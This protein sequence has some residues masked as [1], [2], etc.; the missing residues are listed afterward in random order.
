ME[1]PND[2]VMVEVNTDKD[3]EAQ[4]AAVRWNTLHSHTVSTHTKPNLQPNY[5]FSHTNAK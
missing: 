1:K 3:V 2:I 5:A 4:Q